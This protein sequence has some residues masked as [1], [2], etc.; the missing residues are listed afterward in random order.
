MPRSQN[1]EIQRTNQEEESKA[2]HVT[3]QEEINNDDSK[4]DKDDEDDEDDEDVKDGKDDDDEFIDNQ[5]PENEYRF[6]EEVM[7]IDPADLPPE[8][9][10]DMNSDGTLV[11]LEDNHDDEMDEP[12]DNKEDINQLEEEIG[13]AHV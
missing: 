5:E 1:N 9:V 11:G 4:D 10:V 3:N 7:Y 8:S 13:R 12:Y 2:M 6:N